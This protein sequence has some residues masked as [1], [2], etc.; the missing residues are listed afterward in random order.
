VNEGVNVHPLGS[1]S[2]QVDTISLDQGIPG[3]KFGQIRFIQAYNLKSY[4]GIFIGISEQI[5]IYPSYQINVF[6]VKT[7][8]P[9]PWG[10]SI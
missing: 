7:Y 4:M 9:I 1:T 5:W 8:H 10:D 2:Q 6:I 3:Q